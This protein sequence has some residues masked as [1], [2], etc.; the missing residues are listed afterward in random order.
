MACIREF[1]T[2]RLGLG[3]I[4]DRHPRIMSTVANPYLTWQPPYA[5]HRLCIRHIGSNFQTNYKS[6]LLRDMIKLAG[7]ENQ[8]RKFNRRLRSIRKLNDK[9]A[10]DLE[11][12]PAE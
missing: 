1:V 8:V 7:R 5:Y 10:D 12:I 9:A 3:L 4:S 6:A 2:S 11:I